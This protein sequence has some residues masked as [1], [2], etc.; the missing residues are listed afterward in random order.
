V[1][2]AGREAR[3]GE[4]NDG[5]GLLLKRRSQHCR[6]APSPVQPRLPLPAF[7]DGPRPPGDLT[8][9]PAPVRPAMCHQGCSAPNA[10]HPTTRLA[11]CPLSVAKESSVTNPPAPVRPAVCHQASAPC[12]LTSQGKVGWCRQSWG[13]RLS[14]AGGNSSSIS[15]MRAGCYMSACFFLTPAELLPCMTHRPSYASNH[16]VSLL[17]GQYCH[18]KGSVRVAEV[19][20]LHA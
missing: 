1:Y 2:Q 4:R 3:E 9:P 11:P 13:S 5:T 6:P 19:H 15:S 7:W 8:N 17:R 10:L 20:A 12:Q 18:N 16:S 14:A